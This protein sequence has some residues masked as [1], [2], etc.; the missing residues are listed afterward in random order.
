M[1]TTKK[2]AE[3]AAADY[4]TMNVFQKLQLARVRFLEAGVDKSGKHMKLEYKYFE[5]ADI[6]PKAEQIFLEIGLMMVPSMYGDKATAR[7]YNVNDREDFIDFVAPYT[8]IAPIVSNA[9]NQVT[10]EMQATGSSITYIR[11]YLWQLVLDIIEADNIDASLGSNDGGNDT[12]TPAPKTTKKAP[13]TAEKR[14]EIKKELTDTSVPADEL[15][16]TA[17]KTA[18]K[19]LLELDA[20]QESFVQSVAMKTE[21]FTKI[22]KEVC[23]QLING[24]SEMLAAYDTQEG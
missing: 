20:E 10:N 12:P 14:Q 4:S 6:V 21:G 13:V 9:G 23:E 3:T 7:V 5:L 1:A 22:T 11:R 18:L 8:P 15:Q 2:A 17:L 16:I 19:K 24:V